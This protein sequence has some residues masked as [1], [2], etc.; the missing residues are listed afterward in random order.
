MAGRVA[1]CLLLSVLLSGPALARERLSG[2]VTRV[3]DGDTAT[4]ETDSGKITCRL[5]GIDAPETAKRGKP[6][7]PC[8]D[9]AKEALAALIK[10]QVVEVETTGRKSYRREICFIRKGSLDVNLAMVQ[11][12]YAWAYVEYLKR[13]HA[14]IYIGT[15]EE[16]RKQRLGI[17]TESNPLPPWEFRARQ[18]ELSR[19]SRR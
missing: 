11:K 6:G 10:G 7:Q 17:W 3:T 14:S 9:E 2:T 19:V 18:K 15:E 8:A 13:P 4:I 1:L 5:Y 12:G 16:A